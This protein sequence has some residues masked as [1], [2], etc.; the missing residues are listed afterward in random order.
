MSARHEIDGLV[1]LTEYVFP[2]IP[3]RNMDWSAVTDNYD[4]ADDSHC[5]IGWGATEAEA[6]ADLQEQ[7]DAPPPHEQI[8]THGE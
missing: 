3:T 7:I 8:T 2:Q 5:P 1:I 4:G 6:I